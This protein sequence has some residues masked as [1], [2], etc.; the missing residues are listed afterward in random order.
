MSA[1]DG[2]GRSADD[3]R[4]IVE[5]NY[6]NWRAGLWPDVARSRTASG[7]IRAP[8]RG[9]LSITRGKA[10]ADGDVAEKFYRRAMGYSHEAVKIFMPA[11]CSEPVYAPYT[12]HSPPDT[13]AESLWLRNRQP[14]RWRD[15]QEHEHTG[16]DGA[17]LVE[18]VDT[19]SWP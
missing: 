9:A 16:R 13:Q 10:E 8:L 12:E 14:A 1:R 19:A 15:K 4:L 18:Q 3:Y 7:I 11:G 2:F 17:P 6:A 5:Q